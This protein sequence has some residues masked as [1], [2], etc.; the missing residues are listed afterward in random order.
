M[1]PQKTQNCQSNPDKQ[2]PSRRHHS[3][4][5]QAILQS[6]SHQDSVVLVPKQ[7]HRQWYRI[8]NADT[9]GKLTF[10]KG[11]KNIKWE[12]D[13]LFSKYC[14]ETWTA[15]CKA[16][17]L[18]H[19]LTPCTKNK[20]KMAER[21]K[22]KIRHHQTPGRE[23]RQNILWHQPYKYFLR[24]VSQSNRNKSKNKPMGPNQNDK[25]LHSKGNQKENKKSTYRMEENS[26]KRWNWQ[27]LNL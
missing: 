5:L 13:S 17:K 23:H 10:D 11:G 2:K 25:L 21:L 16:M 22:Y 4:R 26:L 18:E 9:C 19:T 1:E 20:L 8:E 24:S 12:K 27:G 14:W 3:P 7:T 6:H 15:A